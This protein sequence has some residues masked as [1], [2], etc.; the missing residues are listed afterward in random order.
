MKKYY[1]FTWLLCQSFTFFAQEQRLNPAIQIQQLLVAA[2]EREAAL[3]NEVQEARQQIRPHFASKA[4]VSLFDGTFSKLLGSN[5][6]E[7]AFPKVLHPMIENTMSVNTFE[8]MIHDLRKLRL[9]NYA[10]ENYELS[11]QTA[12]GIDIQWDSPVFQQLT[13]FNIQA[14]DRIG[15]LGAGSGWMSFLL[16]TLYDSTFVQINEIQEDMVQRIEQEMDYKLTLS[17]QKRFRTI[18]GTAQTTGMEGAAMD[19]LIAIDA[20]HHFDNKIAMLQAIKSSLAKDGTFYLVEQINEE[21]AR[22]Y[23]P[24][25]LERATLEKLLQQSGFT[26]IKEQPLIGLANGHTIM[27]AYRVK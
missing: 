9:Q 26:K 3:R 23:C 4:D 14:G 2:Y 1:I 24:E 5:A 12:T 7:H 18:L 19:V 11:R 27:F 8:R 25:A 17:Q 15:E 10:F 6:A 22:A 13:F 20:F 21:N 16:G